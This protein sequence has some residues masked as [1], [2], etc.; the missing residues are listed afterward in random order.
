MVPFPPPGAPPPGPQRPGSAGSGHDI[1]AGDWDA[2]AAREAYIARVEAGDID[3]PPPEDD[4]WDDQAAALQAASAA[5]EFSQGA[6]ADV[7]AP[8]P[9]LAAIAHDAGTGAG[10]GEDTLAGVR[11]LTDNQLAGMIGAGN[12]L[13]SWGSSLQIAATAELAS[14]RRTGEPA[15]I[16]AGQST[17][18]FAA[19]EVACEL[20]MTRAAAEEYMGFS[21]QLRH[22]LAATFAA[23]NA[24]II[25]DYRAKVITEAVAFLSDEDA[26][27]VEAMILPAAGRQTVGRLRAALARAVTAV[28]EEAAQR[29]KDA[30]AGEARITMFREDS[31][32]GALSGRELPTDEVLASRQHVDTRARELRAAGIP[33]T[34]RELRVRAFLDL[35]QERDARDGPPLPAASRGRGHNPGDWDD[36]DDDAGDEP[37]EQPG[38]GPSGPPGPQDPGPAGPSG[39]HTSTPATGTRARGTGS[40]TSVAALINITIPLGTMFGTSSVPGEAAGFGLLDPDTA[41]RLTEAAAR[42]QDT[43]WCVTVVAPDGT[44]AAHGCAAGHHLYAADPDKNDRNRDGPSARDG[45]GTPGNPPERGSPPEPGSTPA[46]DRSPG[47]EA[48][49]LGTDF[50]KGLRVKL[51]PITRGPCDHSAYEPGYV[52]SRKLAHLIRARNQRCTAPHCG[53]PAARCDL[54]HTFPWHRGGI[55]CECDLAPLCRHHHRCKQSEGWW[56]K[57]PAPGVLRWTVPSGRQYTTHPDTYPL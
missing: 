23:L 21:E 20:K 4:D 2:D 10:A 11:E 6:Q 14:R 44:A 54:D 56:L 12:R 8:G 15:A 55:T 45:P 47:P 40:R 49:R 3:I 25:D 1:P 19:D 22:R 28:D 51:T 53:Q 36:P 46:R 34:L 48:L 33:G 38:D 5:A 9:L 17:S 31:G 57:Q 41:R 30:A 52:P 13:A 24:G 42:H 32:N 18:E 7:M 26:L 50:L 35:L 29:R 27:K 37:G 43:R 16:R 39:Q